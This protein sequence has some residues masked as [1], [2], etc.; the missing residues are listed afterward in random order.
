MKTDKVLE[1]NNFEYWIYQANKGRNIA[2][3]WQAC[4]KILEEKLKQRD[5]ELIKEIEGMERK[6]TKL[7][8]ISGHTARK[9]HFDMNLNGKGYN[10]ALK[11]IIIKLK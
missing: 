6:I 8:K 4:N 1:E 3:C 2:E 9:Y 7:S 5:K 11:D 10:Q